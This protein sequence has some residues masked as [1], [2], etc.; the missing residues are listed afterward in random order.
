MKITTKKSF[1]VTTALVLLTL[2]LCGWYLSFFNLG[3]EEKQFIKNIENSLKKEGNTVLV[4]D[5]TSFSWDRMCLSSQF[6]D[7]KHSVSSVITKNSELKKQIERT[8]TSWIFFEGNNAVKILSFKRPV[9]VRIQNK[10]YF[11]ANEFEGN[12][13]KSVDEAMFFA[14][15]TNPPCCGKVSQVIYTSKGKIK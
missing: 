7:L 2:I 8:H 4:K 5:V 9:K 15:T 13:C 14:T 1:V 12:L 6:D 10:R 11:F 3:Q